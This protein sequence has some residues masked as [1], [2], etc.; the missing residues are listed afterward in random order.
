MFANRKNFSCQTSLI[1]IVEE[2]RI[3]RDNGAIASI[4]RID[5]SKAFGCLPHRLLLAKLK[6]YG[7]SEDRVLIMASYLSNRFQRV[8]IGDTFSDWLMVVK[9][10]PQGS[11]LGPL[12]FNIFM[13][14]IMYTSFHSSVSS[15]ADD[16]QFFKTVFDA[17]EIQQ[18][19]QADL[20]S[21]SQ[22]FE[23]NAMSLNVSKCRTMWLGEEACNLR[24]I[25]M[26]KV[27]KSV[28]Q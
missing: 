13:N 18:R 9:G 4:V 11:V 27:L 6:A 26:A 19:M 25:L 23:N 28:I 8:K 7:L 12:L 24:F 22:W 5:L 15:Y 10:I 3:A 20:V 16:V 17:T 14:D 1:R 2:L 21:A